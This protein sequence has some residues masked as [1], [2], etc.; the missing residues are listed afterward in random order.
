MINTE[1]L[2]VETTIEDDCSIRVFV[3]YTRESIFYWARKFLAPPSQLHCT[4]LA[5]AM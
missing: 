2:S 4:Y 5:I 3:C 1:W